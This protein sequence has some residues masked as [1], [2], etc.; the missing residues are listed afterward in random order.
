MTAS[1]GSRTE[2]M[3]HT[4]G[5]QKRRYLKTREVRSMIFTVGWKRRKKRSE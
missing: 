3:E 1:V 5:V 2:K 4:N